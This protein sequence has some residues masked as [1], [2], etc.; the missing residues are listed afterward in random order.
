MFLGIINELTA[1]LMLAPNGTRTLATEF[2]SLSSEID[3]AAAAPYALLMILLSPPM[4]YLLFAHPRKQPD[5]DHRAGR[6]RQRPR[7]RFPPRPT[8]SPTT[9]RWPGRASPLAAPEV[10]KG[11]DLTVAQGGTTAI[12]G[13]SGSGKTT[14]L[15]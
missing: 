6:H 7:S 8:M 3:Y 10:L 11:V 5:S 2:W 15:R 14:L 1:T 4:T 12:V 13:A 9:C